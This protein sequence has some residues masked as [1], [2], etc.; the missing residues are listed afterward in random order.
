MAWKLGLSSLLYSESA[1]YVEKEGDLSLKVTRR[2]SCSQS[3]LQSVH[4]CVSSESRQATSILDWELLLL[5]IKSPGRWSVLMHRWLRDS[6]LRAGSGL[7]CPG[8]GYPSYWASLKKGDITFPVLLCCTKL[9]HLNLFSE[10]GI[11]I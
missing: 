7:Q 10:F 1:C 4:W 6:S 9:F 11:N 8:E 3:I 5:R 2:V